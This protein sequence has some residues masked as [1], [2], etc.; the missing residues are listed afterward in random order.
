METDRLVKS[1]RE[2]NCVAD[3][4]RALLDGCVLVSDIGSLMELI[5]G[6]L[7]LNGK[8]TSSSSYI[9]LSEES[10]PFW[11]VYK[12]AEWYENIPMQGI[13]CYVYDSINKSE[14]SLITLVESYDK[15]L[16]HPFKLK[17]SNFH[18]KFAMPLTKEQV[19][20]HC[21]EALEDV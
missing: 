3:L 2:I 18:F 1:G 6:K 8:V 5:D 16:E 19:L 17:N 21:M 9:N 7:F 14:D 13:F 10:V 20:R 11:K 4:M 15:K 12:R